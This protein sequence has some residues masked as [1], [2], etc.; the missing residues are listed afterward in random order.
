MML[1]VGGATSGLTGPTITQTADQNGSTD[2]FTDAAIGAD[3]ADRLVVVCILG[4]NTGGSNRTLTSLSIGGTNGTIHEQFQDSGLSLAI[5][6]RTVTTGATATM[7]STFSG[8]LTDRRFVVYTI[9]GLISSTPHDTSEVAGDTLTLDIPTAG[10]AIMIAASK[11][12]TIGAFTVTGL[13]EN[14]DVTTANAS[15]VATASQTGMGSEVGRTIS[16]TSTAT[17]EAIV[18]VSWA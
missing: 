13:T 10:C 11:N 14:T 5:V 2:T 17:N 4:H 18:A 7:V 1:G 16:A 6:S 9:T 3:A 8:A 12:G 15:Q